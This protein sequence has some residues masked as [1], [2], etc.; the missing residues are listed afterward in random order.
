MRAGEPKDKPATRGPRPTSL[1]L[2][3][4]SVEWNEYE[5]IWNLEANTYSHFLSVHVCRAG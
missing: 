3:N 1:S 5:V 2:W 4:F